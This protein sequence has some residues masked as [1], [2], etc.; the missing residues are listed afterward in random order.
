ML[1]GPEIAAQVKA[2]NIVISNFDPT[3]VGP[4]SYDLTLDKR[5]LVYEKAY[6]THLWSQNF[7]WWNPFTWFP[8]RC[9]PLDPKVKERVV[10]LE[11][12]ET[13]TT[14]YPGVLYLGSTVERTSSRGFIPWIEGRSSMGRLGLGVHITAGLGDD[15]VDLQWTLELTCVHPILIFPGMKICQICFVRTDGESKPYDG[16][17]QGSTGVVASRYHMDPFCPKE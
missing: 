9:A 5:L 15:G 17:Y 11:I 16:K 6:S 7:R 3:K 13:G 12:S 14:L 4:N 1:S 2:G 8:P 10:E